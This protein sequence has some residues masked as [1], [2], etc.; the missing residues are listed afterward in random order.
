MA[1]GSLPFPHLP[2][3][4]LA[5]MLDRVEAGQGM[6]SLCVKAGIS[7]RSYREWRDGSRPKAEFPTADRVLTRLGVFWWEVWTDQNTSPEDL[8]TVT[9][10]FTGEHPD[11]GEQL[12]M[13]A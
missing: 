7:M 9:Y 2:A 13:A 10:A 1:R 12:E 3:A 5:T 6:P 4:P 8:I 11:L